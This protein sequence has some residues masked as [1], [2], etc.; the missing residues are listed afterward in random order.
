MRRRTATV[1]RSTAF[2]PRA[3]PPVELLSGTAAVRAPEP[4]G[5]MATPTLLSL[6]L[7]AADSATGAVVALPARD[8]ILTPDAT[9]SAPVSVSPSNRANCF[10]VPGEPAATQ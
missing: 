6:L 7:D 9:S 8:A 1:C 3:L 4:F 10:H 2:A 5:T